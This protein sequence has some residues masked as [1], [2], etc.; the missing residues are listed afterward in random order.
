MPQRVRQTLYHLPTKRPK[1]GNKVKNA[2]KH[3]R[4]LLASQ[5]ENGAT[6]WTTNALKISEKKL[7]CYGVLHLITPKQPQAKSSAQ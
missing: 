2:V 4:A 6:T 5:K 7:H 1:S 3:H